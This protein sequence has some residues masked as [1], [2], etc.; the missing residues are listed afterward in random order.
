MVNRVRL[1]CPEAVGIRNPYDGN[2]MAIY[3]NI[4]EGVVT[5]SAPDTFTLRKPCKSAASLYRLASMRGGVAG[6][7]EGDEVTTNPYDGLPLE[8]KESKDGF[9][10]DGGFDP[11][12]AS[13][14]LAEFIRLASCGERII[15]TPPEATS[16]EHP[17]DMTPDDSD[18]AHKVVDEETERAAHEMVHAMGADKGH[19][20][21]GCEGRDKPEKPTAK[22]PAAKKPA[23]K[24][25]SKKPAA[26]KP[27]AKKPAAKKPPA[28]KGGEAQ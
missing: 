26:K 17:G 7:A 14:D 16:I 24:K 6:S 11:T 20:S 4:C 12:V 5:Y 27:S 18:A 23:A 8:L 13:M 22:K 15:E 21:V 9:W 10:F 2:E 19:V 25:S 1:T 28:E 3:A